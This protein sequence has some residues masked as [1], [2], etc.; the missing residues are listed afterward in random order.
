MVALAKQH[1]LV[2]HAHT[3]TDGLER[4]FRQDGDARILWAHSG[5]ERPEQVRD[6]LRKYRNLWC[7][8]AFRNEH[9]SSGTV[10]AEWRAVFT[11]FPDRFMVGTDTFTPE[12]CTTSSSMRSGRAPGSRTCHP[13]SPSALHGA[14]AMR[15]L[16]DGLR[17][18][19]DEGSR[20]GRHRV[21]RDAS[22]H[23]HGGRMRRAAFRRDA[24]RGEREI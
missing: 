14:M 20:D 22:R 23:R 13:R 5:F 9:G 10:P 21:R 11:E 2:L 17:P 24:P 18:P 15:C 1:K 19:R 16:P 4:L 6:M 12:R 7:D 8:L 3:D